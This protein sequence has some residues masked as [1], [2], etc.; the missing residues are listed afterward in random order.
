[1]ISVKNTKTIQ[2]T[3]QNKNN[4]SLKEKLIDLKLMW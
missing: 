2:E 1:M 3:V 4:S